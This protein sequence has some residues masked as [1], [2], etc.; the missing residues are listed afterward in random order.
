[1]IKLAYKMQLV[2]FHSLYMYIYIYISTFYHKYHDDID[3]FS[4]GVIH[5]MFKSNFD[6]SMFE[7]ATKK[8]TE[9][10]T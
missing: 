7:I 8:I 4:N 2:T 3:N 1:M 10:I 5:R 9:N 6:L